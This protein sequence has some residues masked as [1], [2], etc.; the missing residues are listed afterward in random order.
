MEKKERQKKSP[1]GCKMN[2]KWWRNQS[3]HLHVSDWATIFPCIWRYLILEQQSSREFQ[4]AYWA[5][6]MPYCLLYLYRA[7]LSCVPLNAH[8]CGYSNVQL[9]RKRNKKQKGKDLE[10]IL[11]T[12]KQNWSL[13]AVS[14]RKLACF[15]V[16]PKAEAKSH[17]LNGC[18]PNN[19]K[20]DSDNNKKMK[21]GG[22]LILL[23]S[24]IK[25]REMVSLFLNPY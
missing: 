9:K 8:T 13:S 25:L 21:W 7:M 1:P 24:W 12:V 15:A 19:K 3:W 4:M 14:S 2:A 22:Y 20:M 10:V 6:V 18:A 17:T 16:P 11:S 23:E 5:C